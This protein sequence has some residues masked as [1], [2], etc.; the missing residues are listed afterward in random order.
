MTKFKRVPV[1]R[2]IRT[3]KHSG[4]TYEYKL[5]YVAYYEDG[6][7]HCISKHETKYFDT[8]NGVKGG[9]Y[10]NPI[11][12]FLKNAFAKAKSVIEAQG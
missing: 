12:K 8:F 4:Y 6:E 9:F 10:M 5:D 7:I 2:E 3:L 1:K 11:P